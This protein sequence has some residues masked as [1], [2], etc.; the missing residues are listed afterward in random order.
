MREVS[1]ADD[2]DSDPAGVANLRI[3]PRVVATPTRS[4]P[5]SVWQPQR[6]PAVT[7]GPWL[8]LARG[9]IVVGMHPDPARV[10]PPDEMVWSRAESDCDAVDEIEVDGRG[11]WMQAGK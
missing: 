6:P 5:G 10:D 4:A 3:T 7:A 9:Q 1:C 2:G 8:T 11:L